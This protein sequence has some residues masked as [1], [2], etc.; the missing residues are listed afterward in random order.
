MRS[1]DVKS[2]AYM[3][4]VFPD[5]GVEI[6]AIKKVQLADH[7]S[8]HTKVQFPNWLTGEGYWPDWNEQPHRQEINRC[9]TASV[10]VKSLIKAELLVLSDVMGA[11]F[12]EKKEQ[13]ILDENDNERILMGNEN[14]TE[15][16]SLALS[17]NTTTGF[18]SK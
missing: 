8:T 10:E 13:V 9:N 18:I 3:P 5:L 12:E 4:T 6:P 1:L 2:A 17:E 16:P 14:G 7:E 15:E 11:L